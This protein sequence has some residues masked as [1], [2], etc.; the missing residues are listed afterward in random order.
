[1]TRPPVTVRPFTDADEEAVVA[2]WQACF[3][4]DPPRNEPA[5]VLRR[6]R[7]VQP[8][9]FLVAL[10]GEELVGTVLGG[11]DG[12]RGWAY[13]LAVAPDRR[14][15]GIGAELMRRLETALASRGCPKLNLQVRASNDEVLAF[16]ES[17]G[18]AV[19]DRVSLGRPLLP[20]QVRD[21][22]AE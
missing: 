5:S 6:K 7:Q 15:R 20:P 1:M 14:R 12:F 18:Y 22:A 2:L 16:Y 13:H 9:L 21:G 4:G 3:P 19:E 8:E 17:L 10:I 11:Y